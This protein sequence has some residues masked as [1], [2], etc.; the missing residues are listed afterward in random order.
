MSRE[1][2]FAHSWTP[3][4]PSTST[5][6][7][8]DQHHLFPTHQ[9]N[10]NVRRSNHPFGIVVNVTYQ[11]L[12]GRVGTNSSGQIVYEPMDNQKGDVA[13]TLYYMFVRY[14]GV[15]GNIW[16]F[17]WLNNTSLPSLSEA[18]QD[19]VVLLNWHR[20]DPP[21]KWEIDRNNYVHSIQQ[22]RNPFIDHPEFVNYIRF[23]DLTKVSP[24]Y[25]TEPS[26][27]ST[28]FNSAA[29]GTGIQLN[30]NDATGSQLPSGYLIIAYNRD[31]YFL[32]IDGQT[33]ANDTILSDGYAA[34]NVPYSDANAFHFSNL[35]P[36]TAY[37]FTIISY[38]G[39]GNQIN[40]K[41]NGTLPRTSSTSTNILAAEPSN[42]LTN[43][44]A[45]NISDNSIQLTWTDAL[46]GSQA[47]LGYL[48]LANDNNSFIIPSDGLQ[49]SNDT[50]L[51][52]GSALINIDFSSADVYSFYGLMPNTNYYFKMYSYNGTGTL[53]NYKTDG[54]V[55]FVSAVTTG[56]VAV[57][58]SVLIDN[59]GR[60]NSTSLGN[61]LSPFD[62]VWN[63]TET[64]SPGSIAISNNRVRAGS[65]TA[66]RD[67]AYLDAGSI[68]EYPKRF[69]SSTGELIWAINMR[70]SRLDPSGF[71]ANNYGAAFIIGKTTNDITSGS[72]YAVVLGQ[73]GSTDAIRL[74]RFTG[75]VNGNSRF[76]NV[77]SAGDYSNQYLSI[78]VV[79]DPSGSNWALYVDSSTAGFPH[80]DPRNA[81]NLIGTASNNTFTDSVLSFVGVLW[82]HSTGANDSLIFDE[83]YGPLASDT[84]LNITVIQEGYFDIG[85]TSLNMKD[86]MKV[87]L[88]NAVSPFAIADSAT[89]L[90]DSITF[91]GEFSFRNT[92]TGNYYIDMSSRN[93]ISTWSKN[94][95]VMTSGAASYYDFTDFENKAYGN[96]LTLKNGKY[97]IFSGDVNQ[98]G[99]ID[100]A[101]LILIFN[102]GSS[103]SSGYVNTDINGDRFVDLTDLIISYNNSANFVSKKIP[104]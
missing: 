48:L 59:F 25:S 23:F 13:R 69:G 97:C 30:W 55:P 95:I 17:D 41:I 90:I 78:K 5:N 22:N 37:Y 24:V 82:N 36:N 11:F 50:V 101:D 31:N 79:Y 67:F 10:A 4:F 1:H 85:S 29:N 86:S 71:D 81:A 7:Y 68:S 9:N 43:L 38:N 27:H 54:T 52:D 28:G 65:T 49:Y 75:G 15:S 12:D 94:P 96:N 42:H 57:S 34:V 21:D 58:G 26:N 66:G 51:S 14:D 77:I 20:Q 80:T 88:R 64:A 39:S 93:T 104:F 89:A 62:L 45:G 84:K 35:V 70:Q 99:N 92:V 87:Y 72:G 91:A 19:T 33:Y 47:P 100:L 40:Y 60:T 83:I 74:A 18:P 2:T 103:F 44:A 102:A 6:Q 61:T 8:A 16:N 53:I 63:E 46:P 3:T 56:N 32:P 73:S 98:E 76:T